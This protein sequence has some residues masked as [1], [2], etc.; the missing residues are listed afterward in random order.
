MTCLKG[1][2]I[3]WR[4]EIWIRKDFFSLS[5]VS[6][7]SFYFLL[8]N[9]I[10]IILYIYVYVCKNVRRCKY[11]IGSN[12]NQEA[13]E[14]IG[15]KELTYTAKATP[16]TTTREPI[17]WW[18]STIRLRET[19]ARKRIVGTTIINSVKNMDLMSGPN[20]SLPPRQNFCKK[21]QFRRIKSQLLWPF[22]F[23]WLH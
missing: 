1:I 19:K 4:I 5:F 18:N 20:T 11:S 14:W 7:V 15:N 2:L 13:T 10:N 12:M 9:C 22:F 8:Y 16:P 6:L 23:F 17:W 21:N 3:I